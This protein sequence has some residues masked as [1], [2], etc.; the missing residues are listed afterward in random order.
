MSNASVSPPQRQRL[1]AVDDQRLNLR[2]LEATLGSR[3]EV[4][5]AMDGEAALA[6]AERE[7]PDLVLL[8]IDMPG[9]SGYDVCRLLK[10]R[11]RTQHIPVIFVTARDD[12]ADETAGFDLGAVDYIHKPYRVPVV[13]ARVR[14]HLALR[15]RTELLERLVA[16]DGL[17]E[18]PNR[19]RFDET[20]AN[21]WRRCG[22]EALPIGL[23]LIDVDF[24]KRYNDAYGHAAGDDCLRAVAQSL[25]SCLRRPADLVARYGGE[26]FACVL[27]ATDTA[28][29]RQV[30]E[31]LR[32][33]VEALQIPHRGSEAAPQVT[34]SVGVASVTPHGEPDQALALLEQADAR[35]YTAKREGRNR[36][37][38]VD[39]PARA[40]EERQAS[41]GS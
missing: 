4:L 39:G 22:R 16:L 26:E 36:V 18:I 29:A 33:G 40:A 37:V 30:A 27:P 17:T 28:G 31:M 19:R 41:R 23:V 1:L 14:T 35:L 12:E 2:L 24:F 3:Y 9:L 20:L 6:I 15:R 7:L 11:Q 10:A 34:I 38:A 32:L 5:T 13:L 8:D 25:S 21:E